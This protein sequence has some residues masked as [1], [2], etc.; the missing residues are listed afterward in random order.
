MTK[1]V[2]VIFCLKKVFFAALWSRITKNPDV[3]AGPLACPFAP[4]ACT[5]HSFACSTLLALLAPS[6]ALTR[7][8][9]RSLKPELMEE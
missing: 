3:S 5:A 8:L 6:A 9:A 7:S 4:F 1:N 2:L